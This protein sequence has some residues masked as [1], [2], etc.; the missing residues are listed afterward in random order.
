MV[1]AQSAVLKGSVDAREEGQREEAT[2][3]DEAYIQHLL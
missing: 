1:G 2:G 3:G